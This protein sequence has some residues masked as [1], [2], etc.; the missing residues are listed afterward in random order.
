MTAADNSDEDDAEVSEQVFYVDENEDDSYETEQ[1]FYSGGKGKGKGK[2]PQRII[3]HWPD[4]D[5]RWKII[6]DDYIICKCEV[7]TAEMKYDLTLSESA[8]GGHTQT[9]G[10]DIREWE[11]SD[12][13][14]YLLPV[15]MNT[16][17]SLDDCEW[18]RP[19]K[20]SYNGKGQGKGSGGA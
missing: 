6:V 4:R 3:I 9:L 8:C 5:G 20:G 13:T 1:A 10:H 14:G 11:L 18:G 7:N 2:G 19:P 12:R 16:C 15:Q 17:A